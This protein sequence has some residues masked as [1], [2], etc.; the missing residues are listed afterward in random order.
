M[1]Q[2]E[3][4]RAQKSAK[5]VQSLVILSQS[6]VTEYRGYKYDPPNHLV[7]LEPETGCWWELPLIPEFE[8]GLPDMCEM[9]ASG[10]NLVIMGGRDRESQEYVDSAFVFD[11]LSYKWRRGANMPGGQRWFFGCASDCDGTIYIAGGYDAKKKNPH[12]SAWAYRVSAGIW[13]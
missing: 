11:F 7:A 8:A 5:K 13:T 4:Y 9:V 6:Q 10:S 2:A 12:K 1:E 3:F